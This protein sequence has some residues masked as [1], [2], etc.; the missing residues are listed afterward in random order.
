MYGE[1]AAAPW[2]NRNISHRVFFIAVA[3]AFGVASI[4]A[5]FLIYWMLHE[6]TREEFLLKF[7]AKQR[8]AIVSLEQDGIFVESMGATGGEDELLV[9]QPQEHYARATDAHL[10]LISMLPGVTSINLD[11]LYVTD[12][13]LRSLVELKD[14]QFLRLSHTQITDEG[15]RHLAGVAKLTN[16]DLPWSAVRGNGLWHLSGLPKL[17]FV[18]LSRSS[19][20]GGLERFSSNSLVNFVLN[21]TQ[22]D[23]AALVAISSNLPALN[24]LEVN[25][26]RITSRGLAALSRLKQL[27]YLEA[28][29]TD[30]DDV[31]IR[32]LS[33]CRDLSR[34]RLNN[35]RITGSGF[36]TYKNHWGLSLNLCLPDYSKRGPDPGEALALSQPRPH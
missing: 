26:T 16:L 28:A 18:G 14:L 15:L 2:Y 32:P 10:R 9:C 34:F 27:N 24:V 5:P 33:A 17:R 29:W 19:V 7:P 8:A 11:A 21:E 12:N 13:G 36:E 25:G 22:I 1:P 20:E 35:T 6:P 23:D 3:A 30:V 4:F 31:G